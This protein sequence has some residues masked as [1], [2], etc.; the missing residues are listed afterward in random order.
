[1]P[2]MQDKFIHLYHAG[3]TVAILQGHCC[4][5][6]VAEVMQLDHRLSQA[7]NISLFFQAL[8]P[9]LIGTPRKVTPASAVRAWAMQDIHL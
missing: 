3:I 1:M 6:V 4:P 7:E 9:E 5:P 8:A 2:V